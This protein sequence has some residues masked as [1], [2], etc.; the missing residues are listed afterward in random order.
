MK[1]APPPSSSPV[2]RCSQCWKPE[3]LCICEALKAEK[4]PL[5]LLILQHPQ[6]ARNDLSTAR[7]LSLS[8]DKTVHVVGHTWRSLG[9]ALGAPK[10]AKIPNRDWAVLFVGTKKK[11]PK[12]QA[13]F[14]LTTRGGESLKPSTL[15][16]IILLDGN[17][18][19][20]KTLWWRNSW[21]LRLPR[22]VLNPSAPSAYHRLRRQPRKNYLSTIEA[23]AFCIEN[24][25]P[26]SPLPAQLR[27]RFDLFLDRC[28]LLEAQRPRPE[29][30]PRPP[31]EQ[32][33]VVDTANLV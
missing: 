15:K 26:K 30:P 29:R 17:W 14:S 18:S 10:T 12:S 33:P 9:H 32:S 2:L 8:V 27:E 23:A 21:L 13:P 4:S 25:N 7:L 5:R 16:G 20:S 1:N 11:L 28:A 22:I 31:R 19:Q 6:E 3:A 24:I